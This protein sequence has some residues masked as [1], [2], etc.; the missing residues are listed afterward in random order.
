MP[1]S[2]VDTID[3]HLAARRASAPFPGTLFFFAGA[4][5]LGATIMMPTLKKLYPTGL[6]APVCRLS[7]EAVCPTPY[8]A[9]FVRLLCLR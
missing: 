4:E 3:S 2:L 7:S 1:F 9:K 8:L 6:V 5:P